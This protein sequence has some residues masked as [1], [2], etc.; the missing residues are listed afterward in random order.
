MPANLL[1]WLADHPDLTSVTAADADV[2]GTADAAAPKSDG[3]CVGRSGDTMATCTAQW[4]VEKPAGFLLTRGWV[5]V[6][7]AASAWL[8]SLVVLRLCRV[9]FDET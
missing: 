1:T 2:A 5:L 6:I 8:L 4:R 9:V 3:S 7:M